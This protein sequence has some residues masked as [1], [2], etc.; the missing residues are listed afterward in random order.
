MKIEK[1]YAFVKFTEANAGKQVSVTLNGWPMMQPVVREKL[2]S[3]NFRITAP[4]LDEALELIRK[5]S[6]NKKQ[7]NKPS[8]ATP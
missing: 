4:S 7:S 2:P 6:V 1:A 8:E 3:G 5:L